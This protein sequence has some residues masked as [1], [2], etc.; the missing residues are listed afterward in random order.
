[1]LIINPKESDSI[2][3][4]LKKYKKKFEKAGVL[5]EIR[6]RKHFEK[7]S[8]SRRAEKLKAIYKQEKYGHK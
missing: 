3:R 6:R 8:V 4:A 2:D 1:M 7:P 5:R